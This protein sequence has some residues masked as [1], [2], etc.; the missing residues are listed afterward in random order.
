[1]NSLNNTNMITFLSLRF[2]TLCIF[3]LYVQNH[4]NNV[5]PHCSPSTPAMLVCA[6]VYWVVSADWP[7]AGPTRS[8]GWPGLI[9]GWRGGGLMIWTTARS[10]IHQI[11][12]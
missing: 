7:G 4:V 3:V 6:G 5:Y 11:Y 8:L 1:M 12:I 9:G 10:D 2:S